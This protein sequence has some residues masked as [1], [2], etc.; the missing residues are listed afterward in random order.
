MDLRQLRYLE[1]VVRLGS[2]TAAAGEQFVA[3]PAVS[4]A[5]KKLEQQVGLRLVIRSSPVS[6]TP[7]GEALVL[8]ARRVLAEVEAAEAELDAVRGIE[9]GI[10]RV[11][12][13]HWLEPF[14]LAQLLGGFNELHPGVD[15]VLR[16]ENADEMF[17]QLS[18]GSLDLVVSNV[19]P[20]DRIPAGLDRWVVV[21][22][23][24]VAAMA[25]P[26]RLAGRS[27]VSLE[28]LAVENLIAFR[29]GSAFRQT[30]DHAFAARGTVPHVGFE[31]SD[32]MAVRTLAAR[33]LGIGIMP[34]SLARAPGPELAV[35][36]IRPKP[37]PRRVAVTWRTGAHTSPAGAAFRA[38]ALDWIE[39]S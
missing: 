7:A 8:R 34:E 22:E 3:Q 12:A 32:M 13:I 19:A 28:A 39:A 11:G 30:V 20:G 35:V 2:F 6:A 38:F 33:G 23:D 4:Q 5:L 31:S 21:T 16:E 36:S 1:A 17:D 14:D 9:T 15:I 25:P 26:H 18:A 27:W 24:L 10:V 29:R 37:E